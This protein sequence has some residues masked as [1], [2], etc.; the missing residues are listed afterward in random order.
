MWRSRNFVLAVKVKPVLQATCDIV[1]CQGWHSET[2]SRL[3]HLEL[4]P[5]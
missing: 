2:V 3:N 5:A 1:A 4:H